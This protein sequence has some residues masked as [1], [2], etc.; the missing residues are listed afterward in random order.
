[1]P[2]R[3][4]PTRFAACMRLSRPPISRASAPARLRLAYDE[5]F[6]N[7]L[8]LARDPAALAPE[9]R[10]AARLSGQAAAGHPRQASLQAHR[11]ASPRA[12]TRS[13]PISRAPTA[14]CACCKAMSA[15]ARPSSRCSP[16]RPRSRPER[17]PRSWR[18]PSFLRAST[19]RPSAASPRRPGLRIAL[20][21]RPREGREREEILAALARG[22][23]RH[24][25]RHPCAV[26]GAGRIPRPRA[27]RDRRAASLRR[28][29]AACAASQGHRARRRASGDDGDA[30]SR[31]RCC[32]P[33]MATWTSRGSTRSR[34]GG[35]RSRPAPC[36]AS[37]W[38]RWW[39]GSAAPSPRARK[40]I[41]SARSLPNREVLD[42]AAAEERHAELQQALRRQGRP[43]AW[44][45]PRQGEGPRH[46]GVRRGRALHSGVDHG[47]RGRRRRA[48]C[49]HHGDRAR[50]AL[51]A[52]A[53]PSA[54]RPG[55][56]RRGA[57]LLHS[58]LP[59]A[60]VGGG[61][62]RGSM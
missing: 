6:A 54:P 48:E 28:A 35:S 39:T 41:G 52:C 5:L 58:A 20:L 15:A 21:T 9:R 53:A 25:H 40:S 43:G 61:A 50:R 29:S 18:R 26:S 62:E 49:V 7:Q 44:P 46:G 38:R 10:T 12:S 36:R 59:Q 45:A 2:G 11:R 47:D 14:C 57:I 32:S 33:A 13:T 16:W 55:R 42:I 51:R 24:S 19:S 37:G 3:L 4:S 56:A 17:R 60:A 30:R 22:T 23:H 31:A 27:C 1:M 34:R 8:A